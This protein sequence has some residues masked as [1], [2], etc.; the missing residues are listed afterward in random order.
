MTGAVKAPSFAAGALLKVV[1]VGE[2]SDDRPVGL[3]KRIFH[4]LQAP[5]SF[6]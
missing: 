5:F 3:L 4:E 1:S 6:V 2:N